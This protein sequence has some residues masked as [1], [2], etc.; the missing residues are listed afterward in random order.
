[1]VVLLVPA[2]TDTRWF[3][4]WVA[5][6]AKVTFLRG[7]LRFGGAD[8]SAPF[9]SMLSVYSP[10]RPAKTCAQCGKKFIGRSDART[11][12]NACRQALYR[13]RIVTAASVTQT[14]VEATAQL[15]KE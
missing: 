7:R 15:S 13:E 4:D 3:H 8:T 6:K 5:N 10:E 9:P 12:S 14:A 2:R 1:L 11:C